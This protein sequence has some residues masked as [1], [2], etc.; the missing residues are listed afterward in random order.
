MPRTNRLD[1]FAFGF[2]QNPDFLFLTKPTLLHFV[3]PFFFAQ[4]STFATSSFSVSGHYLET[5]DRGCILAG[6][7][8]GA[9]RSAFRR[10]N[11][12]S[13][14]R[15]KACRNITNHFGDRGLQS[16]KT[17]RDAWCAPQHDGCV[18]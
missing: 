6:A 2:L 10:T 14:N 4:N 17:F 16:A 3:L 9:C 12:H 18:D 15:P 7:A 8:R 5:S 11:R 13:W 1:R